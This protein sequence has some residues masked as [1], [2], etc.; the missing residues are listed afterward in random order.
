M[1]EKQTI[2]EENKIKKKYR[3]L[4]KLIIKLTK[5][6]ENFL[7]IGGFYSLFSVSTLARFGN[8]QRFHFPNKSHV[9]KF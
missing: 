8:K 9:F 6:I 1:R 2:K 4:K 7:K 5:E 3:N